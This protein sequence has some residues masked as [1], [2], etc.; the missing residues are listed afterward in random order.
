M[1][2]LLLLAGRQYIDAVAHL[3]TIATVIAIAV[4]SVAVTGTATVAIAKTT[5]TIIA[6]AA[7]A[8]TANGHWCS[9]A[10]AA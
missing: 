7:V 8:T 4:Q 6:D 5:S 9:I 1:L 3:A 2:L 10:V